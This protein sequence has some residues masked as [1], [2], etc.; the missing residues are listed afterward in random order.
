MLLTLTVEILERSLLFT[1]MFGY[2]VLWNV[3]VKCRESL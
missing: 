1:Q 2:K 3:R